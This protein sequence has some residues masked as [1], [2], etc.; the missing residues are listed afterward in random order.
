MYHLI[1]LLIIL[2]V[3]V[4][5]MD[6]NGTE[7]FQSY[8]LNRFQTSNFWAPNPIYYDRMPYLKIYKHCSLSSKC[9][10]E[11]FETIISLS[12]KPKLWIYN[13]YY[14]NSKH[15]LNF[16]SRRHR[17]DTYPIIEF[18]IETIH[19]NCNNDFE[20]IIFNQD[21]LNKLI[22]EYLK[23]CRITKDETVF[24]DYV[25]FAIL[26][27]YGGF[28]MPCDTIMLH[29][30]KASFDK[31][32][33]NFFLTFSRNNLNYVNN[34]GFSDKIIAA[35][36]Q[37]SVC[38]K[39]LEMIVKQRNNFG[40]ALYFKNDLNR[41]FNS[42]LQDSLHYH[43]DYNGEQ[44][45][46]N[47]FISAEHLFTVNYVDFKDKDYIKI[48]Y[49]NLWYINDSPNYSYLLRMSKQQI[50]DSNFLITKLLRLGLGLKQTIHYNGFFEGN[51]EIQPENIT[52]HH[53]SYQNVFATP[54]NSLVMK[55]TD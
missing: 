21:D 47:K 42:I 7:K 14:T 32:N 18:C 38:K 44:D 3:A 49:L 5:L 33:K 23:T 4:F 13:P 11:N 51:V 36:A 45:I 55:D 50:L 2:L 16:Y 37:N 6:Y 19:Y 17:Q 29:P 39:M 46:T 15:W 8:I 53:F 25:K 40:Y 31:Y 1:T 35:K 43:F 28:W 27:K 52:P 30:L 54:T 9:P 10:I 48:V 24:E 22:P 41:Y 20:I 34:S 26:E 12:D